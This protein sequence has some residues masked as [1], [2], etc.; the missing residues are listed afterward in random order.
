LP[1]F[2]ARIS[3]AA[4]G[5]ASAANTAAADIRLARYVLPDPVMSPSLL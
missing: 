4:A 3:A 5:I 2:G 1:A